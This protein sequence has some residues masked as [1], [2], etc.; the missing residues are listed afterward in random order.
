MESSF[1]S[2]EDPKQAARSMQALLGP[3]AV[4]HAIRGA[5]TT[6]WMMLPE[7]NRNVTNVEAELRRVFERAISN[8]KDDASVFGIKLG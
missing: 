5:I 4:D 6:C 1:S 7:A 3:Q 2:E 8:F